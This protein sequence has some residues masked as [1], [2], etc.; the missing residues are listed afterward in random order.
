MTGNKKI[1]MCLLLPVFLLGAGVQAS[2]SPLSWYQS[3][4]EGPGGQETYGQSGSTGMVYGDAEDYG[5]AQVSLT[6]HEQKICSNLL[7]GAAVGRTTIPDG[8]MMQVSDLSIGTESVTCPDAIV[9]TV[10]SPDGA[11]EMT[12]IS[13][14]EFE[15]SYTN[16][17]GVESCSADDQYNWTDLT[18]YLNYREA[19]AVCDLM[20]G[21]LYG[22]NQS[23]A[24]EIP[25]TAEETGSIQEFLNTYQ[26]E[27]QQA[28][29]EYTNAGFFVGE[30]VGADVTGAGRVYSDGKKLTTTRAMSMGYELY[31]QGSGY[32]SDII[33]WAIP[34]VYML[35]TD[36]G[37]HDAY[38]E[39]FDVFCASTCVSRE[40]EQMRQ[41]HS[42]QLTNAMLSAKNSGYEYSYSSSDSDYGELGSTTVDSG[43]TYSAFEAWD[44]YIRDETDYTTG[45]GTHVKIPSSYDHVFEGDDG[46]IYAGSSLDGPYGSTEL[47]PTEIGY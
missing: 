13:R 31:L 12:F 34:Q 45:D 26:T 3:Q 46:T 30:L 36:A 7:N 8:W 9:L 47:S 20:T 10:T 32:S 15:Q 40:Y 22:S 27:L 17:L 28:I 6:L 2:A 11:C 38:Q 4:T 14:R 21:V 37:V 42:Q 41:L 25:L 19:D 39:I 44:D 23:L 33:L 16:T 29:A 1:L 43:D 35:R 18:H 24:R 5:E